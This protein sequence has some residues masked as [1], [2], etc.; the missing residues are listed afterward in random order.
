ME[1]T[2]VAPRGTVA[3][4]YTYNEHQGDREGA[5]AEFRGAERREVG[6]LE[7]DDACRKWTRLWAVQRSSSEPTRGTLLNMV[8]QEGN[9]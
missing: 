6:S 3:D 4:I 5:T 1:H 7:E 8:E 9:K 2:T